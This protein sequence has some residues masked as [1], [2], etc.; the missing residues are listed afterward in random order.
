MYM[1]LKIHLDS[2]PLNLENLFYKLKTKHALKRVKSIHS[3]NYNR[4]VTIY[5][6]TNLI[7]LIQIYQLID[8]LKNVQNYIYI[9]IC[10][11]TQMKKIR[12]SI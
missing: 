7:L 1:I 12:Q 6:L 8:V 11:N 3:T 4:N 9:K 10:S 2:K 5:I